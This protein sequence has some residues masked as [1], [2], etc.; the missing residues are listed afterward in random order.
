MN[1][2]LNQALKIFLIFA[3][4]I[5]VAS[6]SIII[7]NKNNNNAKSKND[8]L[9]NVVDESSDSNDT[10]TESKVGDI[11]SKTESQVGKYAD[12]DGDGTV[13]GIIFADLLIGGCTS[14]GSNTYGY[15]EYSVPS[16]TSSKDYYVSQK[17]Y[18]NKL[19]GT[20]DVLTPTGEGN[21][22]FYVMALSDIVSNYHSWYE[23]VGPKSNTI[24]DYGITSEEFGAGKQNTLTMIDKW[25]NNAYGEQSQNDIWGQI[26]DEVNKGWFVPSSKE[27]GVFAGKL[28]I[29]FQADTKGMEASYWTSSVGRYGTDCTSTAIIL[30]EGLIKSSFCSDFY[31]L[32]LATT[33]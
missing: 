7:T 26:Q 23:A 28:K 1:F 18:T 24:T 33:F 30:S 5:G 6:A 27:W 20:A 2:S 19:G 4:A 25:N 22:R 15:N 31:N 3:C 21:D 13:D 8:S 16:I 29:P 14:Y 32:R 12:I 11:V 17:N 10:S 9:W